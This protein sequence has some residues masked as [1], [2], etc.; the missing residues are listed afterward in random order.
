MPRLDHNLTSLS[1]IFL[2]LAIFFEQRLHRILILTEWPRRFAYINKYAPRGKPFS[3]TRNQHQSF[4]KT[5]TALNIHS[6]E[7]LILLDFHI[8]V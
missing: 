5:T 1:R 6:A 2:A 8:F 7:A 4:G 3:V